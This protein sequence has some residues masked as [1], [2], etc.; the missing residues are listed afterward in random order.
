MTKKKRQTV[1]SNN[2]FS[3]RTVVVM[4]LLVI[5]VSVLSLGFYI[6]VFN[7]DAETSSQVVAE[8]SSDSAQGIV[9]LAIIPPPEK[10]E[11]S[12]NNVEK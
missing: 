6:S 11:L 12:K 8:M 2:D 1:S 5:V 7:G 3:N 9:T 10:T 4:L